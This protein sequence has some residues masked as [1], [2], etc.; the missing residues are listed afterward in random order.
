MN[1]TSRQMTFFAQW[2]NDLFHTVGQMTFF[3]P[4]L[5]AEKHCKHWNGIKH[6][7]G[8]DLR[9]LKMPFFE[10]LRLHGEAGAI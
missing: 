9:I 8:F 5:C 6:G 1:L 2:A 3:V 7:N 4:K 10:R